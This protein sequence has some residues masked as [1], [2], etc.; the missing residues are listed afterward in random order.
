MIKDQTPTLILEA[1]YWMNEPA[2][3]D[4]VPEISLY[5]IF[6]T[7]HPQTITIQNRPVTIL[8]D[9]GNTYNFIDQSVVTKLGLTV[10]PNKVFQVMVANRR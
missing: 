9:G 7:K 1:E 8:I 2:L 6:G 4:I 5:A 3:H 10:T